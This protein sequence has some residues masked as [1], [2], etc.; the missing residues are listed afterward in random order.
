MKKYFKI[1]LDVDDILFSCNEY[2]V[3]LANAEYGFSPPMTVEEVR[4]WGET[5]RRTDVLLGYYGR[6]EF[7][8]NQPLLPGAVE[9]VRELSRRAEVF[10][11]TAL[12]THL[13]G[14]RA[15]RLKE[16]FPMVPAKNIIMGFRKELM[17]VA[18]LLDEGL[19]SKEGT[20]ITVS[21]AQYEAL[22]DF[23][24]QKVHLDPSGMSFK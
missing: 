23:L 16:A 15:E 12:P 20:K 22:R 14:I 21:R 6:E 8:R 24:S 19:I 9:F 3:T 17:N 2:A 10:F 4:S 7:V 11:I 5:G 1:G 18:M 13:M